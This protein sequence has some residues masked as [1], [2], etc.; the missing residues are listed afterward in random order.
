MKNKLVRHSF[1]K[2]RNNYKR[3]ISLLFMALLGVGFFV[4][5]KAT[6][7]DMIKSLDVF[8]D[9]NNFYDIELTSNLG[10][11]TADIEQLKKIPNVRI[12]VGGRQQDNYLK[13][14]SREYVV[15]VLNT[16]KGINDVYITQGRL[17]QNEK[18]I[19]VEKRLLRDN[20][21]TI[22]DF[23]T[24]GR[25]NFK[26]VGEVLS[27]L[28]FSMDR[29]MTNIGNGQIKYYVYA[30]DEFFSSDY[31][32]TVYLTVDGAKD[33]ITGDDSYIERITA[34]ADKIENIKSEL[35][36]RRFDE[37]YGEKI[38]SAK[39]MGID[40]DTSK[41]LKAN[42][43]INL[44]SDN[45]A[46]SDVIDAS[47]NLE[48]LGNVFPLVFYLIAILISLITMMRMVE[49][50]RSENGTMKALGYSTFQVLLKYLLFS[51]IATL[52]GGMLGVII[53]CNIIPRII[54]NIYQM[55]FTVPYFVCEINLKY[56]LIGIFIALICICGSAIITCIKNLRDVPATL[57]RPKAPKNG[58]RVLLEEISFI[59]S[60]L[61]FSN[62]ITVRNIFRYKSRV[63]ATIVGIMGCTALIL[64]GFGL[65]DAI[66]DIVSY[67]YEKV[68]HY[69][70]MVVL[71]NS[72]MQKKMKKELEKRQEVA[73]YVSC[74]MNDVK[75]EHAGKHENA[76]LVTSGNYR[77]LDSV[78]S[79]INVDKTESKAVP[80]QGEIVIS[81][82]TSMVFDVDVGEY[83]TI[84][85]NGQKR[86]LKISAIV[87]NYIGQY[88][89]ID[90]LTYQNNFGDYSENTFLLKLA[91]GLRKSE[92]KS[93]DEEVL[94]LA[95]VAALVNVN[96]NIDLV[97]KT[98]NS[99]NSVVVV[100]I[101]AA[102]LLAFVVLYNLSNINISERE[103]EIATLKVLGF[104]NKEVD[105]YITKEN[106]ILTLIG[107]FLG[108]IVGKYLSNFI[109][110]TCEPDTVMFVRKINICSYFVS[111]M[112]TGVFTVLVNLITHFSLLKIDMIESLKNVE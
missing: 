109:I 55:M 82:K 95:E 81:E 29:G 59:W 50:D 80:Q 9:K 8:A 16:T 62:K 66:R 72:G 61:N 41:F 52:L 28:Y 77:K 67:Q 97:E 46:Y 10:F 88:V 25:E 45:Q 73:T 99:L 23:V 1:R 33:D 56:T 71:K 75:I 103:R 7:S 100:L 20:T 101:V 34:V 35:E 51:F 22:G 106:I 63:L 53:G 110:A 6:S 111:A 91:E 84:S 65:R 76:T 19:V 108:L 112:I 86:K 69:S 104:Y 39:V 87:E 36:D 83:L 14:N 4:G 44:R 105:S 11:S 13:V 102:A 93:F 94:G 60:R 21:L 24:I 58:K 38:N 3:F 15:R 18:E 5:I 17:P 70:R 54:W 26:I 85:F 64:A 43:K 12:A 42:L 107:I 89:Y 90:S 74:L 27:P 57:M 32:S 30:S 2:V 78:I 48:K 49:E 92:I 37:V 40:I 31:F 47:D 68:F 98:M 96:E 79:L